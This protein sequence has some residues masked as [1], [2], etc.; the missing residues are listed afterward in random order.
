MFCSLWSSSISSD[1]MAASLRW[2]KYPDLPWRGV[3][4]SDSHN[5]SEDNTATS[6]DGSTKQSLSTSLAFSCSFVPFRTLSENE[7]LLTN[8]FRHSSFGSPQ[9]AISYHLDIS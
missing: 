5:H 8:D 4:E 3:G 6:V 9:L 7:H 1:N 2:Y